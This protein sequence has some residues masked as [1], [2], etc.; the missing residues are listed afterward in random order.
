MKR[1][2]VAPTLNRPASRWAWVLTACLMVAS[3]AWGQPTPQT[4]P[5]APQAQPA[6]PQDG[7]ATGAG[8]VLN[9]DGASLR[10][11]IDI[12]AQRLRINYI[13]DP[14]VDGDVIIRTYG[15][16]RAVEIRSVL[17]TVLRINGASM[18]Q[19]GDLYRI[20]PA[21]DA[22]QLPINPMVNATPD[23]IPAGERL[24]LNLMFLKFATAGEVEGLINPFIGQGAK[25]SSFAPANLLIVLDNARNMRRTMELISLFDSEKLA[26]QRVRSFDIRNGKPTDLATELEKIFKGIALSKESNSL[27][28]IPVDRVNILLA[29]AP[30]PGVFDEVKRWIDKLDVK[31]S[32]ASGSVNNYVYRV[33]YG[34][35]MMLSMAITQ[36]YTGTR[37]GFGYGMGGIGMGGYGTMGMM[38][39]TGMGMGGMG[40]G[41]MMGG[42]AGMTNR[43]FNLGQG[44]AMGGGGAMGTMPGATMGGTTGMGMG[45]G[46]GS[47]GMGGMGMMGG[48]GGYGMG[49]VGSYLGYGGMG[50]PALS[51][52][53]ERIPH[54]IP[55]S[56][57]NTLLIQATAQEYDQITNLLSQI[58][59]PPRQVLIEAKIY[60]VS[61]TGAFAMGVQA[62]LN[63]VGDDRLN[64]GNGGGDDDDDD[65]G[66]GGGSADV[67]RRALAAATSGSG[68]VLTAGMLAGRSREL[69]AVLTAAEDNRLTKV[70]AAPAVI[71]TDSIPATITVGNEVPVLTSQAASAVQTGGT[72]NFAQTISNRQAGI[73]LSI[74]ARVTP[75]GVVTMLLNQD[76]S[77][78]MA[79]SSSG[80]QSPSFNNRTVNTQVTVEDGDTIAIGGIIDE[81]DLESSAGVPYLHRIPVVGGIFGGKSRSTSRTELV[82]FLTPKVIY[83][84]NGVLDATEELKSRM[85]RVLRLM[86]NSSE[87]F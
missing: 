67:A 18:V 41:G 82:V 10:Q 42:G 58:D 77:T 78:P 74:V 68:V 56:L 44:G 49:G 37:F 1:F 57:D 54:V 43:G 23:Q 73:T 38:G 16:I 70:V 15:E 24:V 26:S 52:T 2:R 28:F 36:L 47:M 66:N 25:V 6:T 5:A 65:G 14:R 11:L 86:R 40:M 21:A 85:D 75:S 27:V 80:I 13:L 20:V 34:D 7:E 64:P 32:Q 33:K 45:G 69:L 76:F 39:G 79:P 62:Y 59:L 46:M 71:A 53:G 9:L 61:L 48:M 3:I 72:S 29:V 63:R 87:R 84:T 17:E 30:N 83:D 12:L 35:A 4:Q 31:V 8:L 55:N 60:E 22:V 50:M 81:R 51:P 19:V